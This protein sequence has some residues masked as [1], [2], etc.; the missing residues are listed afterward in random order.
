MG[1]GEGVDFTSMSDANGCD[2]NVHATFLSD[3]QDFFL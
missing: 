2:R 1:Q 3:G